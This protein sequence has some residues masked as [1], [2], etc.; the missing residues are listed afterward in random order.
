MFWGP[1]Y[2]SIYN[3]AYIHLAGQ[4]HPSMMVS[5]CPLRNTI[6]CCEMQN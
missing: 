1:E 4:K 3:E 6:A 5:T 2:I